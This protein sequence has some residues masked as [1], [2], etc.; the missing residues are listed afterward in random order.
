MNQRELVS[1]LA[2]R[3]GFEESDVQ[4]LLVGLIH[5]LTTQMV[6]GNSVVLHGFGTFTVRQL[7]G[8]RFRDKTGEWMWEPSKPEPCFRKGDTLAARFG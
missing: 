7:P 2:A 4:K 6:N 1:I 5:E 3:H 8:R